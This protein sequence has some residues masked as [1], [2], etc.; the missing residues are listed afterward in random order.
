MEKVKDARELLS[1]NPN[2]I[3]KTYADYAN[4]MKALANTARKEYYRLQNDPKEK[5]KNKI[6][7]KA[8]KIFAEEVESLNRKL[9]KA[10][11][12]APRE[13]Q[14]QLMA[15]SRINAA[16]AS[17]NEGKY[18]SAE[19]RKKLRGQCLKQARIDVGASK[20][21]V[22][23]TDKEWEAVQNHA[24][25]ETK[26]NKL[27]QNANSEEYKARALPRE[28]KISDAKKNVVKAYYQA[29]YTYE[30]IAAMTG[31]SQ[32]SISGIVK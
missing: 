15:N 10:E 6:D 2:A 25:G 31:V 11:K 21:R 28:S 9:E 8:K 29:G 32:S 18:D 20:D 19:E 3:E 5:E 17:D 24:I 16:L 12:N 4:H 1:S 27:L 26:L 13:R 30:Q 7:P 22:T 14:A 23:F